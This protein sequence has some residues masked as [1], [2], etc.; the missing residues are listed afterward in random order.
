MAD[1]TARKFVLQADV[2]VSWA[3]RGA[4]WLDTF[5]LKVMSVNASTQVF[6]W[7]LCCVNK[8]LY[9][10]LNCYFDKLKLQ[11]IAQYVEQPSREVCDCV[12]NHCFRAGANKSLKHV[13]FLTGMKNSN[14]PLRDTRR[15]D[16]GGS[17]GGSFPARWLSPPT[18]WRGKIHEMRKC[19]CSFW[20]KENWKGY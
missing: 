15:G 12:S 3:W 10:G 18:T 9:T 11:T 20:M 5:H 6:S 19:N 13:S 2:F 14:F 1:R 7:R 17:V 16:R 4:L 8:I